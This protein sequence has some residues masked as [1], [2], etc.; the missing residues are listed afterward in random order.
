MSQIGANTREAETRYLDF[1][2][3]RKRI[4]NTLHHEFGYA[5][6]VLRPQR[7]FFI[8]RQRLGHGKPGR[9]IK[10]VDGKA[11]PHNEPFHSGGKRRRDDVVTY[12]YVVAER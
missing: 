8:Y 10:T 5:V 2:L 12:A 9:I 6:R 3:T 4:A 11:R 7:I 1:A